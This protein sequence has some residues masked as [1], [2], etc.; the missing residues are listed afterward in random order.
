MKLELLNGV[1]RVINQLKGS[2]NEKQRAKQYLQMLDD[3][4][5][6]SLI[7]E[8][9]TEEKMIEEIFDS[10]EGYEREFWNRGIMESI[11]PD[12]IETKGIVQRVKAEEI[13]QRYFQG[14]RTLESK[15]QDICI[16]Q[17]YAKGRKDE[18]ESKHDLL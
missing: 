17:A 18:K 6:F 12:E 8:E 13:A 5:S 14:I 4:Y 11:Y 1:E 10:F 3:F 9:L 7:D 16:M 2:K 15:K